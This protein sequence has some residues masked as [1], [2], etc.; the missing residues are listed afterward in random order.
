[1]F[2]SPG[3]LAA[4]LSQ[5][6]SA[7]FWP[8]AVV[9][10]FLLVTSGVAELGQSS[11]ASKRDD[12]NL[13]ATSETTTFNPLFDTGQLVPLL[14]TSDVVYDQ[15]WR[16]FP[17]GVEYVPSLKDG[18]W[19][20]DGE[21]MT[22]VWRLKP[23][24][25][26]DGRPV[27]CADYVFTFNVLRD[28]QTPEPV[29]GRPRLISSVS[30]DRAEGRQVTVRWRRRWLGPPSGNFLGNFDVLGGRFVIPR[31]VV[32]RFYRT[33]PSTLDRAAYGTDPR[34]TVGDGPYRW[35]EWRR[36][37]VAILEAVPDH[38][39]FGTPRIR[40]IV[41]R[42]Y[43]TLL[44]MQNAM[45][46]GSLDVLYGVHGSP[47]FAAELQQ[48]EGDR[49]RL[50]SSPGGRFE[51]IDFNLDHP[52]LR[53]LRVRRAIAHTIS[54]PEVWQSAS[55][56][57]RPP[58]RMAHSYLPDLHPGHT[59]DVPTYPYD[60][61]RARRLLREAG[62]TPGPD[63]ILR[64]AGGERLSLE[65]LTGEAPLRR[66]VVRMIQQQL[67]EVGIEVSILSFPSRVFFDLLR[68]RNFKAMILYQLNFAP[69]DTCDG[70]YTSDAIP[71]EQ[72]AW[73]GF[74]YPGYRNPEMDRL[75][76]EAAR[77]LDWERRAELLRRTARIF[78]RDLPA[79]PLVFPSGVDAVRVGLENYKPNFLNTSPTWNAY[80]WYW[81]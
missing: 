57:F 17:H 19:T 28:E 22:L 77:E 70:L 64:N 63:G 67:L 29:W 16:L 71:G 65:L 58:F 56:P 66:A 27:T 36:G 25:W 15:A 45:L 74:N 49:I 20:V 18:T 62:F 80:E 11:P 32:E 44:D 51:H 72:N 55:R 6:V 10:S 60:P 30:C 12:V 78:A 24:R 13:G 53:D 61:A 33:N 79:L 81:K 7:R 3:R 35:V 47:A 37:E 14:F 76:Q 52:V 41:R 2:I 9:L 68:K 5:G 42:M 23:R 46:A 8:L 26:H 43:R 4:P 48:R 38:P 31:H 69:Q 34:V 39:I 21:T 40:R 50:V 75:C 54:R 73:S 59:S 1:M